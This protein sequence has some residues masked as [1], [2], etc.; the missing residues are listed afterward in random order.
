[1]L[2]EPDLRVHALQE[3]ANILT[4]APKIW[5]L[6]DS[7]GYSFFN[8]NTPEDFEKAQTLL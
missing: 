8:V 2:N 4:L 7:E 3:R 1:M 5:K 6:Y